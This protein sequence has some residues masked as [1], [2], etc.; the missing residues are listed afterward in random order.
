MIRVTYVTAKWP[1][2]FLFWCVKII[3]CRLQAKL[4][5][6]IFV[7]TCILIWQLVC[8]SFEAPHLIYVLCRVHSDLSLFSILFPDCSS[9]GINSAWYYFL[10]DQESPLCSNSKIGCP[11]RSQIQLYSEVFFYICFKVYWFFN[12]L[13]GDSL[14]LNLASKGQYL[15]VPAVYKVDKTRGGEENQVGFNLIILTHQDDI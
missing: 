12:L 13:F 15:F 11:Q 14:K 2:T 8:Q 10:G 4:T 1:G 6:F 9:I 7:S 5:H 3:S